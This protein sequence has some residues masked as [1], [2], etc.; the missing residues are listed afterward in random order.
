KLGIGGVSH[1]P[2]DFGFPNISLIPNYTAVSD[3]S[4]PFPTFR[5]DNVYQAGDTI[6]ITRARHTLKLGAQ[7]H[8][9]Q[10]NGV[11]NSHG[12]GAFEF[13]GRFTRDPQNMAATGNEFADYLLGYAS[14]TQRQLGSTRVD[15]R[16][17]YAGV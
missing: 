3:P 15:M 7:V 16:S 11:Q 13:D 10:I 8:R 17:T 1:D 6:S 5:W 4:N 9:V 2:I 14:R 12:R